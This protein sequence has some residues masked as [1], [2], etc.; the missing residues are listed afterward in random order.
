MFINFDATHAGL[1]INRF[2]KA[3]F[4]VGDIADVVVAYQNGD[5]CVCCELD[6]AADA[7]C[8][9]A[10]LAVTSCTREGVEAVYNFIKSTK[11]QE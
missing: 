1:S 7:L 11:E 3:G 2:R 4:V 9:G 10:Y 8:D 5:E 6:G